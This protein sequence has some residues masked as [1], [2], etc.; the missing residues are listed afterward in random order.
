MKYLVGFFVGLLCGIIPL[1]FGLLIKSHLIGIIG[2]VSTALSGILFS[3]L[4]KSPFTAVGIAIVFVV[5]MFAKNKRN[6]VQNERNDHNI[7][8]DDE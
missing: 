1:I 3:T 5:V 6:N 2:T 7:Y 4:E 8:W